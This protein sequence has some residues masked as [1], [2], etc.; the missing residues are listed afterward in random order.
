MRDIQKSICIYNSFPACHAE[1]DT[2]VGVKI[3]NADN[4]W[5]LEG[6]FKLIPERSRENYP[7]D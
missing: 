3:L 2:Y 5:Y 7:N 4:T 6:T 1:Y